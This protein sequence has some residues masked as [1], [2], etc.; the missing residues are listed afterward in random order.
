MET[1][2]APNDRI[3][4]LRASF[5]RQLPA[6]VAEVCRLFRELEADSTAAGV[7]VALHRSLHSIKG[8]EASFGFRDWSLLAAEGEDRVK[9]ILNDR[10]AASGEN[11]RRL[12]TCIGAMETLLQTSVDVGG[13]GSLTPGVGAATTPARRLVDPQIESEPRTAAVLSVLVVDDDRMMRRLMAALL[14]RLGH[15]IVGESADGETAIRMA[16]SLLPDLVLMDVNMPGIGGL[17]ALKAICQA[18][19]GIR[20]IMVSATA[21]SESEEA[22]ASGAC[23]FIA[24]PIDNEELAQAIIAL[25]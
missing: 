23:R 19:A 11:W 15:T 3:S 24:K 1:P 7:A 20:V 4:Q 17:Q 5:V 12:E 21:D 18:Q 13:E 10:V 22:V 14:Q 16:L 8:T 25:F 2:N 9:A 6:R